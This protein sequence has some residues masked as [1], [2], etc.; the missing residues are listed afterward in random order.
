MR[1]I[2][3]SNIADKA[4]QRSI[5]ISSSS[6]EWSSISRSTRSPVAERSSTR[7]SMNGLS[8]LQQGMRRIVNG[9][10]G[11]TPFAEIV[12]GT[13]R[14]LVANSSHVS[15]TTIADDVGMQHRFVRFLFAKVLS[16]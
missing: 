13:K 9:S 8:D 15:L 2:F 12:I 7:S 5:D 1:S 10:F 16:S 14:T 4:T 6:F 11:F 3:D